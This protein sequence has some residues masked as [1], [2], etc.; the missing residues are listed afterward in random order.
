[1]TKILITGGAGAIGSNLSNRLVKSGYKVIVIDNLRSG[2]KE[3]VSPEVIFIKGSIL[4]KNDLNKAFAHCPDY[5]IHMAAFFGNQNSIDHPDQCNLV[6]SRGTIEL[7]DRCCK[8]KIKKVLYASSSC[9]YGNRFPMIESYNGINHGT[10]YVMTKLDGER[11]CKLL[12]KNHDLNT[13]IVRLF[14]SYGPGEFP[15]RY[16]NIIPNFF[17]KA[18][19]NQPL[20]ITGTGEEVRDFNFVDDTVEGILGA[21]FGNT[22]GCAIFNIASARGTKIIELARM[23]N[24]ITENHAGV[25]FFPRRSWDT[26]TRRIGNIEKAFNCFGYRP[27]TTLV[28]GLNKTYQWFKS[29]KKVFYNE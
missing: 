25:E 24:E 11:Y 14:N 28:D 10:P 3:L 17:K 2:H 8:N 29:L 22:V 16:R 7:L 20:P 1:M 21:L 4:S 27:K 13:V 12:A 18:I 19:A 5:V 6:N 9:I 23:I 15:G 26:V